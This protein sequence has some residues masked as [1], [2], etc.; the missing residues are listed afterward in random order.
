MSN[1]KLSFYLCGT[2]VVLS[3]S[4]EHQYQKIQNLKKQVQIAEKK[5]KSA[6]KQQLKSLKDDC[7]WV[8]KSGVVKLDELRVVKT[9]RTNPKIW[10]GNHSYIRLLTRAAVRKPSETILEHVISIINDH[11]REN[12][13]WQ[14]LL[15]EIQYTTF[16]PHAHEWDELIEKMYDILNNT[17]KMQCTITHPKL[18]NKRSPHLKGSA[19]T[20]RL[21][22][23]ESLFAKLF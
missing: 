5:Q 16:G 17:K 11:T 14:K 4:K 7:W 2:K 6:L 22:R 9:M 19:S 13:E 18:R 21:M 23:R 3:K 8:E 12:L 15:A 20:T 1:L 10:E